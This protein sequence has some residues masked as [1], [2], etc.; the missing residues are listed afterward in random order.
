MKHLITAIL[1][2]MTLLSSQAQKVGLVLSG[3]GAKGI[4]H[5]GLIKV[6]EESG[7]PIDYVA[8]T[9]IGAIVAGLYA[10]G[11]SPEEMLDLFNSDDFRL[12]STGTMDKDDLFYF[13][14]K[15]E[16]P[17][18]LKLDITRKA[19]G[20]KII[21]PLNIIPE[22]QM[23]F[24]FMNLTAQTTAACDAD[25]NKLMV[26]FRCVST[27]VY[28]SKAVIHRN[29]DL[30]E[31][32]RAS[33]SFPL[34]YK[35]VEKDGLLL[36]DGGIVNNFPTD[37]MQADFEPDIII[38][39]KVTGMDEKPDPDNLFSQIEAMVTQLTNYEIPDTIGMLLESKLDN[40]GLFD[41]QKANYIYS[42]G[43]E[44]GLQNI[45]SIQHIIQ[46]R[47]SKEEVDQ[48]RAAIKNKKPELIFNNVQVE[49][50]K[51]NQQRKFIIQSIKYKEPL[52]DINQ[53]KSSY[54]KLVANDNIKS[55]QPRAYYNRQTGYFDL[56]FK[57]EPR[58]P[59]DLDFG[60][61]LSTRA[62]TFG[63][64]QA[65]LKL[66]NYRSYKISSNL[67]FG[68]FYNSFSFGG[69]MDSPSRYPF[70]ISGYFTLNYWDYFS[71][72]TDLIFTDI[73]PSYIRQTE[74]NL[75]FEVGIPYTKT[76]IIDFGFSNSK[77]L[78]DYYQTK[79][80]N[81]GDK[82]DQTSFSSYAAHIR[83]DKKKYDFKQYPTEGSRQYF[84]IKYINGTEIFT[85]GTT[86]PVQQ[87]TNQKHSYFQIKALYDKYYQP[88]KFISLGL[89]VEATFNNN[90]LFSNYTSTVLNAPAFSPTPNSQSMFNENYRANQYLASGGKF[91]Y[92]FNTN[93]QLR[94]EAYGF[95][96]I[97]SFLPKQN[98]EVA[99][100]ERVFTKAQFMVLAALVYQTRLGPLSVEMNYYDKVGQKWFLS[101]NYGYMLFNKRGF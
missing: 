78:D 13:Y 87:A 10:S 32:I 97:Q 24:A 5:I 30:G 48:K 36:F 101:I 84:S 52:I 15:D 39:H 92:R 31:A 22:A 85:P 41:F 2:I 50:V 37:I 82:L 54:Y 51:D 83:V 49:G 60:G 34:V 72:S 57:V 20:V 33:M 1:L 8:G 95:F 93:L 14:R 35:P 44:I 74:N 6:L 76:G 90:P 61:H 29:G 77:S 86:A 16:L 45:D 99:Y 23:D 27:D 96:P 68:K 58:K 75:R 59:V 17:D 26:P 11:F 70:Y 55:I 43:V 46:R 25:F 62:N 71:T 12:W 53:L 81:Q 19:T 79:V 9:S 4:S 21:L 67:F 64:L 18:M 40:I 69:R 28:H 56:H 47:V 66:F 91:I 38:G 80:F 3:G 7:I 94:T 73:R 65:N 63:F 100:A 98:N 88:K 42:K 89:M